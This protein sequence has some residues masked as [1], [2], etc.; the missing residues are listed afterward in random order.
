MGWST[1][2]Q[3]T[4]AMARLLQQQG[5]QVVY[6]GLI[7]TGV[8]IHR[9]D[10]DPNQDHEASM[11]RLFAEQ[12]GI[13]PDLPDHE[14]LMA[15]ILEKGKASGDFSHDHSIDDLKRRSSVL[16]S[17]AGSARNYQ[18]ET[19]DGPVT[20]YR[21]REA[22]NL[23]VLGPDLAWSRYARNL[24][25]EQVPGNHGSILEQPHVVE[26][27]ARICANLQASRQL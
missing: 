25:R 26:L 23:D 21:V 7:D 16:A 27:A 10:N 20:L 5:R 22:G 8:F 2:G 18:P 24:K 14:Q 19:Y 6:T 15:Q 4:Y 11:I 9:P 13:G 3:I 1:G 17:Q 12:F